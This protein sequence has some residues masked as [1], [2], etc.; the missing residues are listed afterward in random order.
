MYRKKMLQGLVA[1]G[2]LAA[3]NAPA[4]AMQEEIF[5]YGGYDIFRVQYFDAADRDAI[6]DK[7]N[8]WNV[9]NIYG[10]KRVNGLDYSYNDMMK[11]SM[12]G[13]FNQ[14]AEILYRN[15]RNMNQPA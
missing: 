1:L 15:G 9:K 10:I 3:V 13:A 5:S 4:H 7:N 14:W 11:K 2:I 12:H 6:Q 8:I